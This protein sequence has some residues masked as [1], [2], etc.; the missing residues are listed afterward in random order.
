MVDEVLVNILEEL[1]KRGTFGSFSEDMIQSLLGGVWN[2][3][4]YALK[5]SQ[6]LAGQ[7]EECYYSKG[8]KSFLNGITL[9]YHL[10]GGR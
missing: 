5:D 10:G 2:K 8:I 7:L 4:E 3:V 9:K 1:R 6:N